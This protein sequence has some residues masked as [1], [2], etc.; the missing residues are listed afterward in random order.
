M[1]NELTALIVT[2][3]SIGLIHT[4]L[5]PD[6]YLPFVAMSQ[7]RQWS[8]M[9]TSIVT[10]L[11]GIGHVLSSVVLGFLGIL[12]GIAVT[13]LESAESYRGDLAGWALIAFGLVYMVWGFRQAFKKHRHTHDDGTFH[14]HPH[15][16]AHT[17]PATGKKANI[18][19]WVLFAIFVLGPCEPLI[20]ILMY[21]AANESTLGL[22]LVTIVF[23]VTT[24]GTM[25]G[26]VLLL[27]RG[28]RFFPLQRMERFAHAMAGFVILS[29]GLAVKLGL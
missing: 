22:W 26:M 13:S 20:P 23:S 11:C 14:A 2:A 3:A 16:H 21:P 1:T 19:P 10:I 5:G 28:V 7:A 29:C 6:H 18:T 27:Q 8:T 9:K 4:L 15:S 25:L 17:H 24:I 12:L